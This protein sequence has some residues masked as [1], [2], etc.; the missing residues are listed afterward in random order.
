M[1]EFGDILFSLV[2]VAR[3]A[4]FHPETALYRS[5]AQ[6]EGRFRTME[7]ALRAER[8]D[9]KAMLPVEKETHWQAAKKMYADEY[10]AG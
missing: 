4:G 9:L 7:T 2:N 6:F 3:F 8:L 10:P 1:M 5:T